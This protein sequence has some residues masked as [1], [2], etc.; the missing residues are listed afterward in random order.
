MVNIFSNQRNHLIVLGFI[1]FIG[2]LV[3]F[4]AIQNIPPGLYIDEVS[5]GYNAH[6]IVEVGQDEHGESF[7][8]FFKAFGEYKFPVY[9]YLVSF[10]ELFLGK[11]E[12][13]VRLPSVIAGTFT[14]ALLFVFVRNLIILSQ[15][16]K[17]YHLLPILSSLVLAFLPWHIHFSRAGFEAVV[18]LF[19]TVTAFWLVTEFWRKNKIA[20]FLAAVV[21][22]SASVYSYQAYRVIAPLFVVFVFMYSYFTYK[23]SI[24]HLLIAGLLFAILLF[25][26]LQFSLSEAGSARFSQASAFSVYKNKAFGEKTLLYPMLY[27]KNY[28]SFFSF[29]YLFTHGDQIG[30]HQMPGFGLL[31]R[32]ELPFLL[33]GAWALLKSQRKLLAIIIAILFFVGPIP[34]ALTVPSP[35]SLRGLALTV[36]LSILI[37]LGI[38]Y[39]I[40]QLGQKWKKVVVVF[41]LLIAAFEGLYFFH[42][43]TDHYPKVN[44]L[45]WGAGYKDMIVKVQRHSDSFDEIVIDHNFAFVDTYFRYYDDSIN[46][47]IA[48]NTWEK[49]KEWKKKSVLYIRP[50]YK[51]DDDQGVIDRVYLPNENRDVFAEF[52]KL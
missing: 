13:A 1:I 35:H 27:L 42:Y 4:V 9:I 15:Q 26:V 47:Q 10:F 31:F 46:I 22:F 3:R 18:A 21:C 20:W 7:P 2:F 14:I 43:Y 16:E 11:T 40:S 29:P 32:W 45:D 48:D 5:I 44:L 24:K 51:T 25:P 38:L 36:P 12:I 28:L 50:D 41:M 49:P 17:K 19:F 30:R 39:A 52:W 37:A 6:R 23:T 8:L 34:A 33:F